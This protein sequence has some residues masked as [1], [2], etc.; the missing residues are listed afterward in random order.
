MATVALLIY[1]FID[2]SWPLS[3]SYSFKAFVLVELD[4]ANTNMDRSSHSFYIRLFF[5]FI[6]F[7]ECRAGQHV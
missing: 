4:R 1:F 7:F 5:F 2:F 3:T 6:S